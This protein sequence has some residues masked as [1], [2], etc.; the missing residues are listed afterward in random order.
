ML[1]RSHI[2]SKTAAGQEADRLRHAI[3]EDTF[4]MAPAVVTTT[5]ALTFD[6]FAAL[7][8]ERAR[9]ARRDATHRTNRRAMLR[10][11]GAFSIGGRPVGTK[12][13]GV[14]TESDFELFMTH[15]RAHGRAASTRNHYLQLIKTLSAWGVK[16]GYLA[17][18]WIRPLT[19][20]KLDVD[21]AL[22]REK[23][24]RRN[25]RLR[26]GEEDAVLA[27]A[28]PRLYRVIVAALETGCRVGELLLLLHPGKLVSR[29]R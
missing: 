12:P 14:I 11:L 10:Q 3:R 24:A 1:F 19:E 17:H 27:V 29:R 7:F 4:G 18:P 2:D 20:L 6:A 25:R 8:V 23:V 13:I 5:A 28:K 16:Y 22:R 21:T 15:L 9:P 26:V